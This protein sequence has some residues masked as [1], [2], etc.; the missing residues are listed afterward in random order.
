MG[1]IVINMRRRILCCVNVA[2]GAPCS[3]QR[4]V[5][6]ST[7]RCAGS[8]IAADGAAMGRIG[9]RNAT[10]RDRNVNERAR[11][12]HGGGGGLVWQIVAHE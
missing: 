8:V 2:G 4:N 5:L 7:L 12:A 11:E 3:A 10:R 6:R 1:N 9:L